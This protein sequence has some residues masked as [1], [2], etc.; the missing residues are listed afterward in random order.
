MWCGICQQDRPGIVSMEDDRLTWC[1]C[2]NSLMTC[3]NGLHDPAGSNRDTRKRWLDSPMAMGLDYLT[4]TDVDQSPVTELSRKPPHS[5]IHTRNVGLERRG[6]KERHGTGRLLRTGS[7][8]LVIGSV[9]QV[10]SASFLGWR[11]LLASQGPGWIVLVMLIVG[12]LLLLA[13]FLLNFDYVYR[14]PQEADLSPGQLNSQ[15][16]VL[17]EALKYL[18]RSQTPPVFRE[19][20]ESCSQDEFPLRGK[21]RRG[22][23]A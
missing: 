8:C 22:Q 13:G 10:V 6:S 14:R 16:T 2:C 20:M 15:E 17:P 18:D 4:V 5:G 21:E 7:A 19:I 3:L 1:A 9:I 23:A 11:I 12:Q